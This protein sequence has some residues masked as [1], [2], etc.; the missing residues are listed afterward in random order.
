LWSR[1]GL[2]RFVPLSSSGLQTLRTSGAGFF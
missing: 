1:G 2:Q